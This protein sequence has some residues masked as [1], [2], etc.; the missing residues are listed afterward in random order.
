M[1]RDGRGVSPDAAEAARWLHLAADQGNAR[2]QLDLGVLLA[3]GTGVPADAVTA[4][5]WLALAASR[6]AGDDRD[7]AVEARDAVAAGMTAAQRAE[8]ERRARA[9]KPVTER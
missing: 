3:A 7:R 2:A 9:W 5:V 4:Q 8:A 6:L 1:Y